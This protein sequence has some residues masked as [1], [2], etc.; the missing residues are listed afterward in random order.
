MPD[1]DATTFFRKARE[2]SPRDSEALW[3]LFG[4]FQQEQGWE[5]RFG[6]GR[7][8]GSFLP[9]HV[10]LGHRAVPT[11]YTKGGIYV[12]FDQFP[13]GDDRVA[14]EMEKLADELRRVG[15]PVP[16]EIRDRSPGFE[17]EVWVPGLEGIKETFRAAF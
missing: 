10:S 5:V 11:V 14:P 17:P 6:K 9:T 12:N 4:F 1:W 7:E 8:I 3:E 15:L 13:I 2:R 16:F